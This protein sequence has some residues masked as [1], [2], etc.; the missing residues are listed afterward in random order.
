M[1]NSQVRKI[2]AVGLS[3]QKPP[4]VADHMHLQ[5]KLSV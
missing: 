4:L 1:E 2:I 3:L 5:S